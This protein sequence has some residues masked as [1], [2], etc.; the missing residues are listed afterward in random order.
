MKKRNIVSALT[1][2]SMLASFISCTEKTQE[3]V[4]E[5]Q[6]TPVVTDETTSLQ[7][8]TSQ[9]QKTE[10]KTT[11][12]KPR[13]IETYPDYP[14]SYPEIE[15]SETGDLYE[16][17]SAVL[18]EGLKI[19]AENTEEDKKSFSGEGFVEGFK[20]DGLSSVVFNVNAPTTQHYDFS[21]SIS[22]EK[23]VNCKVYVNDEEINGFRTRQNG[24]FT[25]VTIY[26]VFLQAGETNIKVS[27]DD[28]IKLDYMRISNNTSLSELSYNANSELSNRYAGENAKEVMNF[29]TENYG[30]YIITGQYVSDY[31]NREMEIIHQN[32][33][34]YPVIRFSALNKT[35]DKSNEKELQACADWYNNGGLV[36]LMWYWESPDSKKSVYS[37]DTDFSLFNAMTSEDISLYSIEYIEQMNIDGIISDE[38]LAIVK[39]ID[40]MSAQL[41]KLKEQGVPV[42]W[43]PI[44]EG[45]GEWFWW[46]KS[47]ME[48]YRWLWQ[49]MYSRMTDYFG[50]DNLIWI[51]NGQSAGTIVDKTTFDIA[52][53]D[54]YLESGQDFGSRSDQFAALQKIAGNDKLIALSECS[55]VPD[56]DEL[57][58]DNA[59]WS[60]FGLWYGEYLEDNGEYSEKYASKDLFTRVYNSD[61]ALTLDE[62]KAM[63]ESE[64]TEQPAESPV[65]EYYEEYYDDSYY[66]NGYYYD[67][68]YYY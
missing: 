9:T 46:G 10:E 51:W 31:T 4:P 3:T 14:V 39:D 60:F 7:T 18:S 5:T 13:E 65:E 38:C 42:L 43:R 8:Q 44:H 15:Q 1:V 24:K 29:L 35:D 66:D 28:D 17:E 36:G 37:K 32:T 30:E 20:K 68:G 25:L 33:G 41:L 63:K 55:S 34:K 48:A 6:E 58:R 19:T 62:Y 27:P 49:L 61:G 54:I 40:A 50:L 12:T 45:Y 67:E 22:S 11:Q 2:V 53:V 52:S 64:K 57:F 59:V 23:A 47:G 16:A 56:I 26:G 21:F